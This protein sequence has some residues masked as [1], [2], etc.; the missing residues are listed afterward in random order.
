MTLFSEELAGAHRDARLAEA[1]RAR[2]LRLAREYRL[3][4]RARRAAAQARL[5]LARNL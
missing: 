2:E 4:Q 5:A 3:S 1:E